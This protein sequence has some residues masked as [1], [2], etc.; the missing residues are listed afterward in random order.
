M[1]SYEVSVVILDIALT[2]LS[3]MIWAMVL[4]AGPGKV[5][6]GQGDFEKNRRKEREGE[7]EGE[8]ER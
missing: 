5:Y 6:I 8:K 3:L 2:N 4:A 7:R 1:C